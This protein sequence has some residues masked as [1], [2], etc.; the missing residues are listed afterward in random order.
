MAQNPRDHGRILIVAMKR[1]RPP[2]V[3]ARISI[4]KIRRRSSAYARW[5]RGRRGGGPG[6]AAGASHGPAATEARGTDDAGTAGARAERW[7][8]Q[9]LTMMRRP[10][11]RVQRA[12][13]GM[14]GGAEYKVRIGGYLFVRQIRAR[15]GAAPLSKY[16]DR[17]RSAGRGATN[18]DSWHLIVIHT[19]TV[20]GPARR[21]RR[22]LMPAPNASAPSVEHERLR[23]NGAAW[24]A[25]DL[26]QRARV[27]H[28][29]RGLQRRRTAWDYLPHD[30]AARA[31]TDGARTASPASATSSSG[32]ASR[33]RSGTAT[34][35]S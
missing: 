29:A 8:R 17:L 3:Q 14:C 26:R 35:R 23:T 20:A 33:S 27:G 12:L 10:R 34:T 6:D 13:L 15:S 21:P 32:S 4:S 18:G 22:V 5:R 28:G 9:Q 25:W 2:Q 24:R 1:R 30:H 16:L 19:T 7:R 31:R 11:M